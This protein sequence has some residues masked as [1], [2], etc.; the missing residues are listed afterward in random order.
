MGRK[1]PQPYSL[2]RWYDDSADLDRIHRAIKLNGEA[3][4]MKKYQAFLKP[5]RRRNNGHRS[6]IY[7]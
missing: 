6:N 3:D 5:V 1:Y 4:P 7:R 2:R